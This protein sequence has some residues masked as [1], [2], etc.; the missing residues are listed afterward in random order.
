MAEQLREGL[1]VDAAFDGEGGVG[2]A[3]GMRCEGI[4]ECESAS[5]LF[6]AE[7]DGAGGEGLEISSVDK[8]G[9]SQ[10]VG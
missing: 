4:W 2:V 6:E 1:E 3:Q 7:L 9:G 5:E 10:A 8:E